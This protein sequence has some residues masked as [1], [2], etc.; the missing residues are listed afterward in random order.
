LLASVHGKSGVP[1]AATLLVALMA[2]LCCLLSSH[3]LVVFTSALVVFSLGLVSIAVLRGR[4]SG[5]TGQPGYWRSPLYPLAPVLGLCI[6]L[7]FG[8][9]D[10]LDATEGRPSFLILGSILLLA[11]G[12]YHAVLRRRAGGWAPK[13]V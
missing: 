8:V 3:V 4:A 9:A 1:L 7:T 5:L 10:L 2:A 6:A 12:W 13:L 11:L